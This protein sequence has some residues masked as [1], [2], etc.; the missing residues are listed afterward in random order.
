MRDKPETGDRETNASINIP[1]KIKR[2]RED[3]LS[4]RAV[5]LDEVVVYEKGKHQDGQFRE[6]FGDEVDIL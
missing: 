1:T 4:S 2:V 3:T 5:Y 6:E